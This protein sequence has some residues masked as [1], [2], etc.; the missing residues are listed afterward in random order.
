LKVEGSFE[1][2]QLSH[3]Q[4]LTKAMG[5]PNYITPKG[6]KKIRDELKHLLYDERPKI[7]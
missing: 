5:Q 3:F 2:L 4:P 7:V 6:L 1:Y